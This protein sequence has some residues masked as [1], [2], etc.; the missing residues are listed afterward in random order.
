MTS[1]QLPW[2]A[3]DLE[4]RGEIGRESNVEQGYQAFA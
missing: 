3:G 4:F 1:G 2:I